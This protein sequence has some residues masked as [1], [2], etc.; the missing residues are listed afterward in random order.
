M[1]ITSLKPTKFENRQAK[2][3]EQSPEKKIPSEIV[4][5]TPEQDCFMVI[6]RGPKEYQERD[7]LISNHYYLAKAV[8][9][10]YDSKLNGK[11]PLQEL[12]NAASNGLFDAAERF[13][14]E[15]GAA[16]KTYC[17]YRILGGV[18]DLLRAND[19]VP[20]SVR[21]KYNRIEQATKTLQNELGRKANI[22]EI[23]ARLECKPEEIEKVTQRV[24]NKTL[25]LEDI[26]IDTNAYQ[27]NTSSEGVEI[28]KN[29]KDDEI[30]DPHHLLEQQELSQNIEKAI[31]SLNEQEQE[32]I[33][34]YNEEGLT[35][36][37]ISIALNLT[38]GR[39]CQ[40]HTKAVTK[41]KNYFEKNKLI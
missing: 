11:I 34:L 27:E 8:A 10:A 17:R 21:V 25:S 39:I 7:E 37:E 5:I 30:Y 29:I 20:R 16:F 36:K 26:I 35:M 4:I 41:I 28:N 9:K 24:K 1:F 22:E 19:H 13:D 18:K 2:A 38:E 12:I 14:P 23:A 31:Y 40:I 3:Q 32:V 6:E 33:R 15:K